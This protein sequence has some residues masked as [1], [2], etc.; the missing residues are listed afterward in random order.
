[1]LMLLA[2]PISVAGIRAVLVTHDEGDARVMAQRGFRLAAGR[3]LPVRPSPD[4]A[5]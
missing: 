1:M 3:L 2:L 4:P 5:S